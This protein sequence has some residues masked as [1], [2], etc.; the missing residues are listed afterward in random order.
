MADQP[1]GDTTNSGS[2]SP[3]QESSGSSPVLPD[4]K[5]TATPRQEQRTLNPNDPR[6]RKK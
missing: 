5:E 6:L 1:K 4:P 2:S 3:S